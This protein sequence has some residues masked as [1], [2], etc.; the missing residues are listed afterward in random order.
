MGSI[1]ITPTTYGIQLGCKPNILLYQ[2]S[3]RLFPDA[4]LVAVASQGL[5]RSNIGKVRTSSITAGLPG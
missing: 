1:S 5:F 2:K 4:P 3:I